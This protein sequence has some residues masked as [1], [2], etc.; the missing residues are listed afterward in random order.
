MPKHLLPVPHHAGT[1]RCKSVTS[2]L[3]ARDRQIP[4]LYG[5][6]GASDGDLA[7]PCEQIT[8]GLFSPGCTREKPYPHSADESAQ[9]DHGHAGQ[10]P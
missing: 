5:K 7:I 6:I 8:D 2:C 4:A 9:L 1:R 10:T 3:L